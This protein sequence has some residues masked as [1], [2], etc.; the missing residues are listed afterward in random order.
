VRI[1]PGRYEEYAPHEI[2]GV[3]YNMCVSVKAK[4]LAIIGAGQEATVIG[5]ET[6][7][8]N[9][10]SIGIECSSGSMTVSSVTVEGVEEGIDAAYGDVTIQACQFIG[11]TFGVLVS[12][13]ADCNINSCS[14]QE[15][16]YGVWTYSG[17]DVTHIVNCDFTS[18]IY[19]AVGVEAQSRHW[20]QVEDSRFHE[21][22][23]MGVQYSLHANGRITGCTF[24][25]C[26]FSS[27]EVD[28]GSSL[29]IDDCEM[30]GG[31]HNIYGG[32]HCVITG[33]GNTLHGGTDSTIALQ[34]TDA[35]MTDS[36]IRSQPGGWLI[37]LFNYVE[38]PVL[39]LDFTHN[40]WGYDDADSIAALIWDGND[41]P[42][43]YGVVDF[44]PFNAP[45]VANEDVSWGE[46]KELYR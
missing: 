27:V 21:L 46:L 12:V 26:A 40:D 24:T 38:L 13:D 15:N 33:S 44:E 32:V 31:V 25:D 36:V 19:N 10:V 23:S 20:T 43:L 41:D 18:S 11:C 37:W 9:V 14:F 16:N 29:I 1:G 3:M 30:T 6:D 45:Q 8:S 39:H 28:N 22:G 4:D 35:G 7:M 34:E 17:S 5:F 2:S 42:S